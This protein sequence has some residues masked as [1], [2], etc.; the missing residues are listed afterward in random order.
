M[1]AG[2]RFAQNQDQ[3]HRHHQ[4]CPGLRRA[5]RGALRHTPQSTFRRAFRFRAQTGA[6]KAGAETINARTAGAGPVSALTVIM[7]CILLPGMGCTSPAPAAASTP[8]P[9]QLTY[10]LQVY[11]D[12]EGDVTLQPPGRDFPV[13]AVVTVFA[14]PKPGSRFAYFV[15]HNQKITA[16]TIRFTMKTDLIVTAVFLRE[17]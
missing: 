11:V 13:G 17:Q 3:T 12:G 4:S 2:G 14:Y 16:S 6:L 15:Y 7:L 5:F 8:T 10:R 1:R 9:G